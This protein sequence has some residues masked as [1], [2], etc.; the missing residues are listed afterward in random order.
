MAATGTVNYNDPCQQ[1]EGFGGSACYDASLL[2]SYAYRETVYDLLFRDLGMDILRIKSTYDSF[3]GE[4]TATGQIVAEA[5]EAG[6]NPNL[7]TFL[8]PWSPPA[9]LK[10]NN[11]V[12]GGPTGTATLKKDTYGNYMYAEYATWWLNS[13]TGSGGFNSMGIYPDYVSIQN[14]PDW[15]YTDQACRFRTTEN[16][17]Y[18]GY[19]KAFEAVY[20]KLDGN[21][22]PMPKML[23]PETVGFGS[24]QAFITALNSRGQ[25]PNIY[26][27]SHH[28]YGDG[29]YNQPDAMIPGMQSYHQNYGYKPLFQTEFGGGDPPTVEDAIFLAQLIH[30]CLVYEGVTSYF[31][32]TSF[33]ASYTTG[34]MINL[35]SGGPEIRDLYW[36]FKAYSYFTD[37]NWYL[38][39]ATPS[40]STNLRMTAFKNPDNSKLTV[41]ILNKSGSAETL[42]LTLNGC[43]YISSEIYR[44]SSAEH[45]VYLGEFSNP[46]V[47]PAY[48]I[49]TISFNVTIGGAYT[50]S[51]SAS[52]GGT[53]KTPGIGD[54][55]YAENIDANIV[56]VADQYYHFVN[57][58]GTAVAAGRVANPNSASTTV[59]MDADYTVNANFEF[60]PPDYNAPTPNP[61]TWATVPTA[62][63]SHTITMTASTASDISGVEYSFDCLTA[64]GHDSGWQ[65][66]PTYTD[67]GLNPGISYTYRVRARDKS[68]NQ[69]A[70]G[71]SSSHA[72]VTLPASVGLIGSWVSG[73][74]HAK[75]SGS[76]RALILI[77]HAESTT[78]CDLNTVTYGGQSM[79]KVMEYN[80]NVSGGYAYAAAFILK[81]TGVAAASNSTFT[82]TWGGTAPGS[83]AYSSAFFSSVN[84]TTSTGATGTG[85]TTSNTVTT[86]SSLA[87]S[88]GD[89]VVLGATCGNEGSYTLNNGFIEGTDQPFGG[90]VTGVTGHKSATGANETP[91]ATYTGGVNR[92]MIIGFVIKL[93]QQPVYGSCADVLAGGFRLTSDINGTGDCY[94]DLDDLDTLVAY[95]LN[96]NCA[97]LNN[98]QG[99]DLDAGGIVDFF[100]FDEFASQWLSCNDPENPDCM[101]NW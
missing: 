85:G 88:S 66:N 70:T 98:C 25:L 90:T 44:S 20:N 65:D 40:P 82:P 58:T 52:G 36:F 87:T 45:W 41:V 3:P 83:A 74:N 93:V 94:T 13:L 4:V 21:V 101:Q 89:M 1:I 14:E 16:S 7:K 39:D 24:S 32:W 5:R 10:S 29:D 81:E 77:A 43:A 11:D 60:N 6:R 86:S 68:L 56:A 9:Y 59:Y 80:Y 51:C 95:W 54:F 64:V 99:A 33:R 17:S 35:K 37:P 46:I 61:M 92:Q 100:D 28:L 55:N 42:S 84:Q 47:L 67:T 96:K 50:L 48:S 8:L 73:T 63:G 26:G 2:T 71:W 53:V 78:T 31:Q 18:A 19:D 30:N 69:N 57:W 23:A 27:F 49:T 15:G 79:T 62:T 22:S 12:N 75:E 38:L 72:A 97:S 34:G 91:S 76:N